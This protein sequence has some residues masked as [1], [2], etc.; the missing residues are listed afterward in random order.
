MLLERKMALKYIGIFF[1]KYAKSLTPTYLTTALIIHFSFLVQREIILLSTVQKKAFICQSKDLNHKNY[2][3][4]YPTL[5]NFND[6][7]G[8]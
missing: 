4:G 3:D 6:C 7:Q 8:S 1:A 5:S 2:S